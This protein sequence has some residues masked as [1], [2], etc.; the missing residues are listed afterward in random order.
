MARTVISPSKLGDTIADLIR[1]YSDDV[2]KA[3]PDAVKEVAQDT[4][5]SLKQSA[6]S[7][8]GG[9]KY[10]KSFHAKKE[11][12]TADKTNYIIYSSE[13]R[14]AHLLEHGHIIT[15]Q[16]GRVYGTTQARPH[17][18]PAEEEAVEALERK[19]KEAV[20]NS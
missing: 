19:L 4:V 13:Y 14:L 9:K 2:I 7:K 1:N 16:T 8:F 3:M 12:S 5:K 15:N 10:K 20:E 17:W 6:G 11:V 18:K